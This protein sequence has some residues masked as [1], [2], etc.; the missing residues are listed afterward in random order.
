MQVQHTGGSID[1][2]R[3]PY[4]HVLMHCVAC[5]HNGLCT[6][7]A[8]AD[9]R[10]PAE[11]AHTLFTGAVIPPGQRMWTTAILHCL[12]SLHVIG[13]LLFRPV[14]DALETTQQR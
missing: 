12:G 1:S 8:G 6:L 5:S 4:A 2:A 11:R 14:E 10:V 9:R 7:V 13:K 3:F